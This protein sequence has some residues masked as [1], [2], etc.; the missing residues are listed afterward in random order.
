MRLHIT[1]GHR[2]AHIQ[3]YA[4]ESATPE[5]PNH[6]AI[7]LD[8]AEVRAPQISKGHGNHRHATRT[9]YSLLS[10]ALQNLHDAALELLQRAVFGN[11]AFREDGQQVAAFEHLGSGIKRSLIR[12][13]VLSTRCYRYRFGEAKQPAQ[14]GHFE[15]VVVH[16]KVNW[17]RAGRHQQH[18][19]HKAHVVA[20][21]NGSAGG[22]D[23]VIARDL[24][25]VDKVRQHPR[26]KAQQILGYQHE[27]VKRHHRIGKPS[28]Q[29]DLRNREVVLEQQPGDDRAGNHEQR[30]QNIIGGD[31]AGAV[32]GLAAQLDQR[33]HR[34]AVQPG[35]QA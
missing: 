35:K 14:H 30:V 6:R 2:G 25:A 29:E 28:E 7:F 4:A 19:V 24:E 22:G 16:Q 10:R 27:D 21:Q 15:N 13:R 34:H 12:G 32:R 9:R 18:G 8:P 26:H 20:R 33:I 1:C 17:A 31:D 11:A 3:T 23:V 5:R